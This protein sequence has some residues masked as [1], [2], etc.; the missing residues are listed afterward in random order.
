MGEN[1]AAA[2]D[3][4]RLASQVAWHNV[5]LEPYLLSP[6]HGHGRWSD[7]RG[8]NDTHEQVQVSHANANIVKHGG[9]PAHEERECR[10]GDVVHAHELLAGR[11][12]IDVGLVDIVSRD[13][14]Y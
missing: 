2:Q 12:R 14:R 6:Y 5:Q 13:G 4:K 7:C 3:Y 9:E 1:V 11:F 10:H 8:D